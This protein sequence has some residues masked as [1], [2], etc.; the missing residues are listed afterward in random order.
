MY[1]KTNT[2]T[3]QQNTYFYELQIIKNCQVKLP[4]V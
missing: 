2:D 1:A 3:L 4:Y